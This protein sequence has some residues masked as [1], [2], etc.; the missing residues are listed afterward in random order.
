MTKISIVCSINRKIHCS[1]T[2]KHDNLAS[3]IREY[4]RRKRLRLIERTFG[5]NADTCPKCHALH[6]WMLGDFKPE[7][8]RR[9]DA[10]LDR[11]INLFGAH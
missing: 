11:D 2:L 9:C 4:G 10:T 5:K 3:K 1:L 8:C 7:K 6:I